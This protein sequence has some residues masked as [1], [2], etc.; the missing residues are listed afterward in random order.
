[1]G[2]VGKRDAEALAAA[3]EPVF[4]SLTLTSLQQLNARIAVNGEEAEAV[5]RDYLK[6]HHFAP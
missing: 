1:M 5:A 3:L 4:A 6:S 2:V